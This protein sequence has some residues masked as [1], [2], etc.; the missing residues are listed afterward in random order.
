MIL[1]AEVVYIDRV[2]LKYHLKEDSDRILLYMASNGLV[3]NAAKTVFMILN[4]TKAEKAETK[5]D[6]I[7]VDGVTI[8]LFI[9]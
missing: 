3:A 9:N 1:E 5:F 7:E 2:R 6:E 8:K 4:R